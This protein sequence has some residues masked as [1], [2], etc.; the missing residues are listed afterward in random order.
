MNEIMRHVAAQS[1]QI[2]LLTAAV[3]IITFALRRG[4]A[5][6]RYLLWL[7]VV[8]KCLV[9]PLHVMPLRVLPPVLTRTS[10][11][12]PL[13]ARSTDPSPIPSP[14]LPDALRVLHEALSFPVDR[15]VDA[16]PSAS[17]TVLLSPLGRAATILWLIGAA[18]YLA[19]NLLRAVRGHCQLQ[20]TRKPLPCS[21]QADAADLLG[22]YGARRLPRVYSVD[23][24]SQPFV[25]GLLRGS[26]YVPPSFLSLE[27]PE[28][29]RDILAHELSHVLRFDAA[30]NALQIIAQSLFWFHPFVWWANRKIRREREK[31]CDEMVIARLHTPPKDYSTAIVETLARAGKSDRSV[32]SLAVASPVRHIEGRIRAIL[33]PGKRFH[34]RPSLPVVT[35]VILA[36][37]AA[38]P[39]TLVVTALTLEPIALP[40]PLAEFPHVLNGW[41]GEDLEIPTT[42]QEYMRANF[43]DDFISRRYT[44]EATRQSADLYVVYCSSR[45][46]GI[47]RHQ[48]LRCYAANGWIWDHATSQS[49]VTPSN[50]LFPLA[51]HRFRHPPTQRQVA[52]AC[53]YMADNEFVSEQD[54]S[55]RLAR[56]TSQ[57]RP[58]YVAQV[59]ISSSQEDSVH[60]AASAMVDAFVEAFGI[61]GPS[62]L[63]IEGAERRPG[64]EEAGNGTESRQ[65]RLAVRR[66]NSELAFDVFVQ[67]TLP[68]LPDLDPA[69]IA[70]GPKK[71]IGHT[72]ATAP[73]AI[74]AGRIWW[75]T[76]SAPVQ[77]W[78][79]L[80][81]ELDA[82]GVPGLMLP[83]ATDLDM[84][85]LAG[86]PRLKYL[87]L[88]SSQITDAGLASLRNL[89]QLERLSLPFA[90]VTDAGLAHLAGMTSLRILDLSYTQVTDAGL[91]HLK[92]MVGLWCLCVWGDP[93]TDAGVA[94]LQGLTKLQF[95]DLRETQISDAGL[96]HLAGLSELQALFLGNPR[97]TGSGLAYLKD[98]PRLR[99]LVLVNTQ[100]TDD[101][102]IHLAGMTKLQGLALSG[103]RITNAGIAHL[104]NLAG[105]QF[106]ELENTRITNAGLASLGEMTQLQWLDLT[107]EEI[108]DA[109]LEQLKSLTGLEHLTIRGKQITTAGQQRLKKALPNLT[110]D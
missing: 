4:S 80:I 13:P 109:G 84:E 35:L 29:R 56:E 110:T 92:G 31:C 10:P 93:V 52:V 11:A 8:A 5:H 41:T 89:T 54:L 45:P 87:D 104:H 99:G 77:D 76:P 82:N 75:V 20:K 42:V 61:R 49:V 86:L 91:A 71:C 23:G 58:R 73:V 32:P 3:A 7:V 6:V 103:P 94:N 25:W 51:M 17:T 19:M 43:A 90:K 78:N 67:E 108:T 40:V 74:P 21:I 12:S 2:A 1:W 106:L 105:L 22:A 97:I 63:I 81:R 30:V 68:H 44:N 60:S 59:Q 50:R 24:V 85:H 38:V 79:R 47:L 27:S 15:G 18:S 9:P 14:I 62:L 102:L 26:I 98:L 96:A 48:P 107:G 66:F 72:P 70:S 65:S 69:I 37:L 64:A 88:A 33:R 57:D 28:H 55:L 36:A 83:M 46:S 16:R 53:F 95:L 100:V 101:S 39:T 34:A